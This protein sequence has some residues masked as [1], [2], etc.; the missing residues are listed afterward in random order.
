MARRRSS[1]HGIW[2]TVKR[3]RGFLIIASPRSSFLLINSQVCAC[4]AL[5]L[6]PCDMLIDLLILK[7]YHLGHEELGILS[8]RLNAD[9]WEND[10]NL[11]KIRE[12]RGYSYMV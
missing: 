5:I 9:N 4:P 10:E 7:F 12:A 1:K 11:K 6:N 2:M 3:T 8:W